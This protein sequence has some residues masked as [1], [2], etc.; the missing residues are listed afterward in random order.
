MGVGGRGVTSGPGSCSLLE[1][2]AALPSA[3]GRSPL[4][5]H[6][7]QRPTET[8]VGIQEGSGGVSGW[9]AMRES[10]PEGKQC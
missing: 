2:E 7:P 10:E 4:H 5:V 8:A 1:R 3:S 9:A 6:P